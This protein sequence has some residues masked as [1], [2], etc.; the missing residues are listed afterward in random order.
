MFIQYAI[1]EEITGDELIIIRAE[2]LREGIWQFRLIGDYI[3]NNAIITHGFLKEN[4]SRR[5]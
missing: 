4:C 5:Y 3:V 2:N 1:P